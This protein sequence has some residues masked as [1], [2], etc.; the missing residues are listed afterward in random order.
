MPLAP[1]PTP[2]A[3]LTAAAA[4]RVALGAQ[5][6]A[7]PR[8]SGR[9]DTR[10]LRRV[11]DRVGLL[12]LDSVNVFCRAH[13][14][15]VFSRLGPYPRELLDRLAGHTT[16]GGA[17]LPSDPAKRELF[18]YWAHEA[19]LVPVA[20]QRLL[21]WRMAR[22][23]SDAWRSVAR[24]AQEQPGLVEK[25]LR[26][27]G[28]Q[29]PITAAQT[30]VVPARREAGEMWSWHDGK[31]ALE[32]L[33]FSGHVTAAGRVNFQRLYDLPERVLPA[34]TLAAETPTE[35]DAQRELV[36]IA[37][38][39]LGVAAEPDLGDYFRLPRAAS[40]AR[41]AELVEEGE[42][43]PVEVEGW[44]VPAYLWPQARRPRRIRARALLSPF[45]SLVFSRARTERLFGFR[46]RIEIYTPAAK[47]THGYYVLP[48]LLDEALVARVDLKAD[49]Q[50][51]VLRVQGA[52]A[53][54]G[55]ER[56]RVAGELADELKL[57]ASWLGLDGVDVRPN[58]DL[59]RELA[60][61]VRG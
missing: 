59:A 44:G 32:Y 11:I 10:H 31:T 52:F 22:A 20:L 58:G 56:P 25:V 18:E 23:D 12:Q 33:F 24:L 45:D 2:A 7:E 39:C 1:R 60:A 50:A 40:K 15:P 54:P 38:R 16:A 4:R 36:R 9:I 30:G 37:A 53:E 35:A 49:R 51:G 5:G 42:L 26:L 48:F 8:P 13:Y 17:P 61:A 43:L 47:R 46:Y 14:M 34:A 6:F 27:V 3:R 41:V 19:S 21:R 28:E 55:V 57:A 29:G